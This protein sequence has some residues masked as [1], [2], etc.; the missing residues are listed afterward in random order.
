MTPVRILLIEDN[1]EDAALIQEALVAEQGNTF[2][3]T[4]VRRLSEGL[5]H[6]A[7]HE[8]DVVLLDLRLPDS[9]GVGTITRVR[10][11][12]PEVPVLVLTGSDDTGIAIDAV[13]QGAED[14]LVKGYVQVYP[15]LLSR[16][17]RYAL[18]RQRA[19]EQ[20]RHAHA[21][22]EQLLF[23]IPSTLIRVSHDGRITHW[24]AVAEA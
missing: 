13:K 2:T 5:H 15:T 8:A 12:A 22:T 16:A 6:L 4:H 1:A 7:H 14:Y 11:Q 9:E 19:E 23:S 21:Q 24:N 18:E 20:V 10:Q 17:I 3:L